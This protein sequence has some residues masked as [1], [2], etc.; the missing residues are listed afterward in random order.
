MLSLDFDG[1][2]EVY[3]S[4]CVVFHQLQS[5]QPAQ[6]SLPE[7]DQSY[8]KIFFQANRPKTHNIGLNYVH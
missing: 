2:K 5:T 8:S 4:S 3:C 6:E 1:P 7:A